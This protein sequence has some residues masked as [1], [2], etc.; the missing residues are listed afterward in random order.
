MKRSRGTSNGNATGSAASRRKRKQRML[1]PYGGHGGNGET[2]PCYRCRQPL[3]YATLTVDRIV[4]GMDGGSY[5]WPNVRP[6]CQECNIATGNQL[7]WHRRKFP[8]GS[9]V[10]FATNRR[11]WTADKVLWDIVDG[12][13][14]PLLTLRSRE[15]GR[16]RYN[17]SRNRLLAV[18]EPEEAR[19]A[20]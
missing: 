20:A 19:A 15:S 6:A 3:T 10:V 12:E 14:E 9:P 5:A 2:V 1:Q 7:K 11:F 17:V 4:A 16:R 13:G 18:S 8:K